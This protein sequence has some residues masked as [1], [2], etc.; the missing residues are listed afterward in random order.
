MIYFDSAATSLHRPPEV[1]EAVLRAIG[2]FGNPSRGAHGYAM[3]AVRAVECA[4]SRAAELFGCASPERVAFTTNATEAL[5]IAITSVDGH[6]VSTEAEH[7]SVLRPLYRKGDF[8]LVPVDGAGR[9]DAAAIAEH[10]R[11]DTAAAVVTQASNLTGNVAPIA[12]IGRMCRE[13]GIL[14]IVDAAQTAGLLDIDMGGLGIDAL[15]FTGH[16]SLYGMQGTGGICL[17]ERF[18]PRPLVVGG[19]G[20]RTFEME[21]PADLPQVLEAGTLN[22]H[23]IAGLSAGMSYVLERGPASL[24]ACANGL[25]RTFV[26]EMRGVRGVVMYGEYEAA[27]RVPIVALNLGD[28][29]SAEVAGE[30]WEGHGIAVRPGAHCAPLLHKRF[31]TEDRG[32]VRFSF[33][34]F[35]TEKEVAVA[36][37]ALSEISRKYC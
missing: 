13:R 20:N 28:V 30:L 7:N 18:S 27:E 6:I 14:L 2:E 24:L 26:A 19:S 35:N 36:V 21:Q 29:D 12:E 4:R 1:A 25:A 31:G 11:P 37:R 5:N 10:A 23:G 3:S 15:C 8:S 17:S 22:A 33:S 16:K 9:Y 32:A 34:P